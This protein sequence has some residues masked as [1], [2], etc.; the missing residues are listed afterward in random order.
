VDQQAAGQRTRIR[1]ADAILHTQVRFEPPGQLRRTA[2]AGQA[3]AHATWH[4]GVSDCDPHCGYLTLW[5]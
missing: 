4:A 3:Q 5:R 2:Q 1:G